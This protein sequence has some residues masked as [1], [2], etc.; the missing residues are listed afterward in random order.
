VGRAFGWQPLRGRPAAPAAEGKKPIT[1]TEEARVKKG[2]EIVSALASGGTVVPMKHKSEWAV[3]RDAQ[4]KRRCEA[5]K[6]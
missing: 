2:L 3:R 4:T 5:A 1:G 6:G